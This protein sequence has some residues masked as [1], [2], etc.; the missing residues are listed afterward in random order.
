M[1]NK[2]ALLSIC[3]PTYNR[4]KYLK[5]CLESIVNQEWFNENDIEIVISDNASEDNTTE[6]VKSYQE[7]YKNIIY[8]KNNENLWFDKNLDNTLNKASWKFCWTLSDDEI[9]INGWLNSIKN[10]IINNIDIWYIWISKINNDWNYIKL[11]DWN[12]LINI[13]WIL[14]LWLIS[15]NI[16]NRTLLPKNRSIYFWNL[17]IHVSIMFEI[18]KNSSLIITNKLIL[19][20]NNSVCRWAKWWKVFYTFINL[21][22]IILDNIKIG[23][24]EKIINNYIKSFV[25][26]F[27]KNLISAKIQWLECSFNEFKILFNEFY[28]YPIIFIISILIF[29]IPN[30]LLILAK[31][32][33]KW[34]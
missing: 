22:N 5:E 16:F 31:K 26:S 10:I 25:K 30:K 11:K 4:E 12:N 7:K 8:F 34:Q 27:P 24:N 19:E 15:H 21:K 6:L 1:E 32:L 33:I 29:I 28:K 9:I 14:W 23:Y 18:I 20:S 3:I 13:Y 2:E 17:R